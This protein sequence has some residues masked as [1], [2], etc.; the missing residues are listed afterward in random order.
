MVKIYIY[1]YKY[2]L[3]VVFHPSYR[4]IPPIS[5]RYSTHLMG[6]IPPTI[7]T[8]PVTLHLWAGSIHG[9]NTYLWK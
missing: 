7:R 6:D 8:G 4:D 5:C 3:M 2:L 1:G 9:L